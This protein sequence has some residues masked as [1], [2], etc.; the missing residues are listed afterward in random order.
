[1]KEHE[2]ENK[3]RKGSAQNEKEESLGTQLYDNFIEWMEDYTVHGCPNI[4]KAKYTITRIL[5]VIVV[6]AMI[7]YLTYSKILF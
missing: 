5:W 3:S 7:G 1:M 6:F 4:S 2:S